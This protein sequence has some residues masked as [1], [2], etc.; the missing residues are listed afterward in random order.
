LP[1]PMIPFPAGCGRAAY[2]RQDRAFGGQR[3]Y[4]TGQ[5]T[6]AAPDRPCSATRSRCRAG[7]RSSRRCR[8]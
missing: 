8:P 4:G 6:P 5:A 2:G 7:R 3:R 1:L